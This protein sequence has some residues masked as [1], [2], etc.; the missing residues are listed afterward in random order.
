[1]ATKEAGPTPSSSNGAAFVELTTGDLEDLTRA[2]RLLE[3]GS[4]AARV[5]DS[6]GKPVEHLLGALPAGL[7]GVV[8]TATNKALQRG[9]DVAIKSLGTARVRR[10]DVLHRVAV[11][12]TGAIGGAFG[13]ATL[14]LELPAST[15]IMLRSIAEIARTEGEVLTSA[16]ARLACLEVFALGGASR[17]REA[18]ES[19]YFALRAVMATALKEAAE[20]VAQHG[21]ARRGAPALLRFVAI[22][23]ERFGLVVSE[24]I[25]AEA[26]PVIGAVGGATINVLFLGYFQDLAR[27]HFIVRRLERTYGQAAVRNAY[28]TV[29][30]VLPPASSPSN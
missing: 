8:S 11:G 2:K 7:A 21:L 30:L 4:L 28:A 24:K 9:L 17:T 19:G 15:T 12:A 23:A 25:L 16:E 26:I 10:S 5:A 18:A 6:L 3:S 29:P 27:G 14:A 20:H 13:L 22:V 1:M